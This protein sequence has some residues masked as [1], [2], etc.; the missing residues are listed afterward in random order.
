MRSI[1]QRLACAFFLLGLIACATL[2]DFDP[3]AKPPEGGT[4]GDT[5]SGPSSTSG[6]TEPGGQPRGDASTASSSGGSSSGGAID[7]SDEQRPVC[8]LKQNDE[9]CGASAECCSNSCREDRKCH[10]DCTPQGD[11]CFPPSPDCCIGSYCRVGFPP[12]CSPCI[13]AGL[14]ADN[15]QPRS[16]CSGLVQVGG[17]CK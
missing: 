17:K 8:A 4:S 16:C 7:A 15:N 10:T 2:A 13:A 9:A 3:D 5:P 12:T 14:D 11:V 6:G 1:A